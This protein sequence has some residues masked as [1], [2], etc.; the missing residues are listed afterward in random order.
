MVTAMCD[1]AGQLEGSEEEEV[2]LIT[3]G[4]VL[5]IGAFT[6][7]DSELNDGRWI[8]RS[9]IGGCCRNVRI[10]SIPTKGCWS[11]LFFLHLA[12]EPQALARSG[13]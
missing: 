12:P 1:R 7:E 11:Q 3:E 9:S 10:N 4:D 6:L 8:D 13:C 2:G 5:P